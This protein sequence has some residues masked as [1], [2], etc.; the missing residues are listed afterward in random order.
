MLRYISTSNN[1]V[2]EDRYLAETA[3]RSKRST[4]SD[5]SRQLSLATGTTVS[6]QTKYRHLGYIGQY[7]CKPVRCVLFTETHC[8]HWLAWSREHATC[9]YR[10]RKHVWGFPTSKGLA[11]GL[12]HFGRLSYGEYQVIVIS[13]ARSLNGTVTVRGGKGSRTELSV[14]IGT[15]TGQLK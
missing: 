13:K 15:M 3:K 6:R 11:S 14:Q 2:Y 12:I 10:H 1:H 7:S 9:G 5:L 4:V 8:R